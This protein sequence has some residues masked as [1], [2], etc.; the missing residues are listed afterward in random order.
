VMP[1]AFESLRT[2]AER[3]RFQL[4]QAHRAPRQAFYRAHVLTPSGAPCAARC[5]TTSSRHC[6]ISVPAGAVATSQNPLSVACTANANRPAF[7]VILPGA[8]AR[9]RDWSEAVL[10]SIALHASQRQPVGPARC[11][12]TRCEISLRQQH[13]ACGEVEYLDVGVDG[14]RSRRRRTG[15][16]GQ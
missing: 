11:P 12:A 14:Y 8:A 3:T 13:K 5:A 16:S 6:G 10:T 7:T 4:T 1:V 9:E 15:S 2:T